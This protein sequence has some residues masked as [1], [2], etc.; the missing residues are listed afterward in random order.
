MKPWGPMD[1]LF[2][3]LHLSSPVVVGCISAERRSVAVPSALHTWGAR[4]ISL[5]RVDDGDDRYAK[6]IE[7]KIAENLQELR[8]T[9]V[10]REEDAQLF[11]SD[12][13]I[14]DTLGD[15]LA[16]VVVVLSLSSTLAVFQSDS[17]FL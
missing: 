10:S 4:E 14:A 17:F 11:A 12:E 1:W 3:K 2:P 16:G 9:T 6:R 7:A 5:L 8:R 13:D 15:W